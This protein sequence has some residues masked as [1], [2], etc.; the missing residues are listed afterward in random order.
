MKSSQEIIEEQKAWISSGKIGC[1]FASALVKQADKIGWMFRVKGDFDF[2]DIRNHAFIVSWIFPGYD[3]M[4]VREWALNYGMYA[5]STTDP[6]KYWSA[7][8]G[9]EDG[10]E[11][12]RIDMPEG[13]SWVQYFGPDSHVETRKAPHPMLSFTVKLPTHIYA[14]TMAVGVLHLAHASIEF[15]SAKVCDTLWNQSYAATK[16]ILGHSP[17]SPREAAKTTFIK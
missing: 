7:K 14:K 16:K 2:I 15:L 3:A 5:V 11:G 6:N 9:R 8:L 17:V 4:L 13:T 10:Y 12:L 1:V